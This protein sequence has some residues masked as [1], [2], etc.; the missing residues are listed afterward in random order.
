MS[1]IY[2]TLDDGPSEGKVRR[3]LALLL[4]PDSIMQ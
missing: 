4:K 2:A 3:E 1:E